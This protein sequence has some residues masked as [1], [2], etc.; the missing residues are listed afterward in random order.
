MSRYQVYV[1][2]RF[3]ETPCLCYDTAHDPNAKSAKKA[4][5]DFAENY[6]RETGHC[7]HEIREVVE[8]G[9]KR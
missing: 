5:E 9:G 7:N 6:C 3:G 1:Q 2:H 8:T 4:A